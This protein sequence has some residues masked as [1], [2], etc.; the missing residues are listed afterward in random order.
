MLH[1]GDFSQARVVISQITAAIFPELVFLF[2]FY[3]RCMFPQ[4]VATAAGH[5]VELN[6]LLVNVN[7][8][9]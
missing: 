9:S 4:C 5:Q 8:V 2:Y 3:Y 6:R 7:Q 1:K